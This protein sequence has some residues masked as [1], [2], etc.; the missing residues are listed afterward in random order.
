[1]FLLSRA[2]SAIGTNPASGWV[3]LVGVIWI[4][5]MTY[6]CYRGIE[7]SAK[8]QKILLGIE[9]VMLLVLSVTALVKVGAGQPPAGVGASER[10][11]A[12]PDQPADFPPSS[13][14]SS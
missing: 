8:F 2:D 3:L 14:G 12:A 7:V 5:A 13:A 6:I 9:I 4:I 1:M 10:Q 11:L